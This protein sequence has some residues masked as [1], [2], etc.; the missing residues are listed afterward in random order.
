M[1]STDDFVR[2]AVNKVE[3]DFSEG[4]EVA[5]YNQDFWVLKAFMRQSLSEGLRLPKGLERLESQ[6]FRNPSVFECGGVELFYALIYSTTLQ[7]LGKPRSYTLNII[8]GKM[9][10]TVDAVIVVGPNGEEVIILPSRT[11]WGLAEANQEFYWLWLL[12]E[13]QSLNYWPFVDEFSV[14]TSAVGPQICQTVWG[15]CELG[16]Q[17]ANV[18]LD[19][20][21]ETK[22]LM[23]QREGKSQLIV[24]A[25]LA[26]QLFMILHEYGHLASGSP[27]D[28]RLIGRGA[29]KLFFTG[30]KDSETAA[31]L[32]AAERL[33]DA[34]RSGWLFGNSLAERNYPH[35]GTFLLFEY[36]ELLRRRGFP[37]VGV[38]CGLPR[39]RWDRISGVLLGVSTPEDKAHVVDWVN[40]TRRRFDDL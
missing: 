6:A 35:L 23:L 2:W 34:V 22:C 3:R 37:V 33:R 11:F 21:K 10:A 26:Q 30:G 24:G 9:P 7:L 1:T 29:R 39:E 18:I 13:Y 36:L 17:N 31:D 8:A 4:R 16:C 40:E 28:S 19:Y 25:T 32:W 38:L 14:L 27:S 15:A 20:G 5:P 12:N